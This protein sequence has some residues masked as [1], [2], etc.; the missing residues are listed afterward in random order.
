MTYSWNENRDT[1]EMNGGTVPQVDNA[2]ENYEARLDGA[3]ACGGITHF[4]ICH[5]EDGVIQNETLSFDCNAESSI[6]IQLLDWE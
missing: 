3:A 6:R 4:Y 2:D 1:Y 5:Q